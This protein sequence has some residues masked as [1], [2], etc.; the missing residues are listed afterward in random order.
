MQAFKQRADTMWSSESANIEPISFDSFEK[1]VCSNEKLLLLLNKETGLAPY[2]HEFIEGVQDPQILSGFVSAI[3]SFMGEVTGK[4][5]SQWTTVFDSDSIILVESGEWSVGVL[6]AAKETSEVRSKLRIVVREFEDCFEFLRDVEG[7]QNIFYDFDNYV[8]R[9]FIDERITNRTL[10]TKSPE[11]RNSLSIFN[12][13]SIVFEVSKVLLGFEEST[14]VQ[15]IAEFQNIRIEKVIET[16][17]KAFWNGIVS[18][19]YIPSDDDILALSEKA[20]TILFRKSN[21]LKLSAS[22]L[23]VVARLDGRTPLS[24]FINDTFIQDQELL[25]ANLG[26]LINSGLV[27]RISVE[28]R[29]VL[30]NECIL[31]HLVSKGASIVGSLAMNQYFGAVCVLGR[32]VHP[33][34][35]RIVLSDGIHVTCVLEESMTPIDLDDM[36]D[37]LEYFVEEIVKHLSKKCGILMVDRLLEKIRNECRRNWAPYL[38]NVVI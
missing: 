33:W 35:S 7:I 38:S 31:S 37:A 9:V 17:S 19:R 26:S 29:F 22:C 28:K 30:F 2:S 32:S 24:Q 11:W 18:L 27:Q 14:T 21:P 20:S 4:E 6:V 25:L 16:V 5:H 23:S 10:V 13:P 8:R 36:S 15:E 3:S 12:L 1:S 34:I